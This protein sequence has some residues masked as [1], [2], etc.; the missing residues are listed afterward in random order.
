[1]GYQLG[2]DLG[3]T[4][5]AAAVIRNGRA[6]VATLGTRS[7]EIPSVVLLRSDGE[8][9]I[10]EAAERRSLTEPDR[11]AREFKR[12]MGDPTPVLLGGSPFSAH[13]LMA[14]LLRG[15]VKVVADREGGP[16]EHIVVTCP[17]NW[18]D[19]KRDL[20]AQAVRQADVGRVSIATEPEAAAVHYAS[21]TR[22]APGEIVAVYDLGG[23]TFDAAVL[24]NTGEGFEL[25]GDPRGI[26]QLG[27][28][29]FDE[30]VF[31]WVV[32]HMAEAFAQLDP[33]D[34]A[35]M[36]AVS[37]LRRDCVEA[38]ESLSWDTDT[39]IPV[40]LPNQRTEARLTRIEFEDMIRPTLVDTL[41]A[42]HRSLDSAGVRPEQLKSVLLVGGS[43]RIPLVG[44]LLVADLKR[45]VAIDVHPK[46][47]V[48]LGAA[49]LA[50][51]DTGAVAV[52]AEGATT[53]L[54]PPVVTRTGRMTVTGPA[55][56]GPEMA[57]AAAPAAVT[58]PQTPP[59]PTTG[60]G[61]WQ[62]SAP[63]PGEAPPWGPDGGARL[64]RAGED[65]AARPPAHGPSRRAGSGDRSRRR[66]NPVVLG[67]AALVVIVA[68]G[69]VAAVAVL[70][71]DDADRGDT[72]SDPP[73]GS[74]TDGDGDEVAVE[75]PPDIPRGAPLATSTIAYTQVDGTFWNVWLIEADGS[76]PRALTHENEDKARLPVISPD[77]TAVAYSVETSAG[78]ELRVSDSGGTAGRTL[79]QD[80]VSDG[81]A[82]W[83]PDGGRIAFVADP[84][85][86]KDVYV[87]DLATAAMT[88]LTNTPEDDGD[89]AWS[90]DGATIAYWSQGTDGQDIWTI[91]VEGGT[92]TRLTQQPGDDADPAWSPD[93][94]RLAFASN[95]SGNWDVFVMAADGRDQQ[96]L[97]TH[98]ADDQDPAWAPE[99]TFIAFETKRDSTDRPEDDWA[100]IYSMLPDGRDQVRVT[101]RDGL[102]IH[103]AWGL[104]PSS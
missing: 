97:T 81:R 6:E 55:E 99:G 85:G 2:V 13:A 61:G 5:T 28:V 18:G 46:H 37:R 57:A 15:V 96:P 25:L 68:V 48:A 17:A 9:L 34:P 104:A 21:T 65:G 40:A 82:T 75:L 29:Y 63:G 38:K 11:F 45:P 43:S 87:F 14:R 88:N 23:G 62:T 89:P 74:D 24:R 86:A 66:L 50:A 64:P 73:A 93:S 36:A 100:E 83:S 31:A 39:A 49:H 41:D 70:G 90:P 42:V 76:N 27:G 12:R 16:P 52:A 77:R 80:I 4:Y 58:A 69:A 1:V 60:P 26:E 78:W 67:S 71:G 20:L 47:A 101:T 79:T 30:A 44:Q 33:D 95:R 35:A 8:M 22:V 91:P 103:P 3:T 98:A 94:E 32:D 92:P 51:S 53:M 102:D 72:T 7:L 19:Y 84:D 10:G 59:A 54:E 56:A